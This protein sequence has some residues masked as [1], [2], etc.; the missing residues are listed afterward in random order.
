MANVVLFVEAMMI[1]LLN[2]HTNHTLTTAHNLQVKQSDLERALCCLSKT[3]RLI[4]DSDKKADIALV[5]SLERLSS[6]ID[7][8]IRLQGESRP[9]MLIITL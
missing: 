6:C 3:F 1:P 9:N 5:D 4:S 7:S 8:P 2:V